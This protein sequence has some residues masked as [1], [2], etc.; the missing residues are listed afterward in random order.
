VLVS[1]GRPRRPRR[2]LI[3]S[4]SP[5][6]HISGGGQGGVANRRS[7]TVPTSNAV[8]YRFVLDP[9]E[10]CKKPLAVGGWQLDI[11]ETSQQL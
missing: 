4:D 10:S 6:R 2:L 7:T 9:V 8:V 11:A 3:D 5:R 1:D